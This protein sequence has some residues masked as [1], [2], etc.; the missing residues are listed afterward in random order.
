MKV[1]LS[2]ELELERDIHSPQVVKTPFLECTEAANLSP[3][4]V[5]D[6][7]ERCSEE[8]FGIER[9]VHLACWKLDVALA[10]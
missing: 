3:N 2:V 1:Q 6:L 8:S 4:I 5:L 7:N 10:E 9:D